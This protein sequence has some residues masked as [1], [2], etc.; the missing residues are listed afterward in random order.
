MRPEIYK[1]YDKRWKD[2]PYPGSGSYMENSGCG[3]MAVYHAAI[4]RDKYKN[5]TV[6]KCRDY[7]VQFA[8]VKNGTLW[9]GITAGL[10]HYGYNVHWREADSMDD[11]FKQ[12]KSSL[13]SGII[14]FAKKNAWSVGPDG[15]LWT[16]SGHYIYF[17]DYKIEKDGTHW[18]YL[19][20]S[21]SRDHDG[22]F[23]FEKSMKGCCRNV[24][25][26]KSAKDKPVPTPTPTPTPDDGHYH[27]LYPSVRLYLEPGDKGENVTRLQNYLDWYFDGKFFKEC[28]KA[29]GVYGKQCLCA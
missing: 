3:C 7:M 8:T 17:G 10:E 24:W 21:G 25:I 23:C 14:L 6:P 5:L 12:L 22:W 27:G 2:L 20:D 29:D 28:G 9:D 18:F 13:K 1:Q 16:K 4:E 19:K 26:C 11:I 15:T